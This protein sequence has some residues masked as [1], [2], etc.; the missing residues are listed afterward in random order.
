MKKLII[1]LYFIN[2]NV[3]A[4]NE[5]KALQDSIEKK[6]FIKYRQINDPKYGHISSYVMAVYKEDLNIED[7]DSTNKNQVSLVFPKDF[8]VMDTNGGFYNKIYI[9][10]NTKDTIFIKRQDATVDGLKDYFYLK[11]NWYQIRSNGFSECGNSYF[12]SK[13]L[14]YKKAYLELVNYSL[15]NGTEKVKY[16]ISIDLNDKEYFSNEIEIHL[17]KKQL[18]RLKKIISKKT[19][20][21]TN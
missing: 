8:Q 11:G 17:Y 9:E 18:K 15:T 14:P 19:K 3:Y 21:K 10:N 6:A 4:Q 12:K 2:V 1:L 7:T 20:N 5:L 16:K 13:L